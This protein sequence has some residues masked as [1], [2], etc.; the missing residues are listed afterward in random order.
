MLRRL[1]T[2]T[3]LACLTLPAATLSA[4]TESVAQQSGQ[5]DASVLQARAEGV[6]A[7][8][9]GEANA[10]EVFAPSFLAEVPAE[11]LRALASQLAGQFGTLQRLD[12]VTQAPDGS[13]IIAI[14][15]ENALAKGP[16]SLG[17]APGFLVQG[18]LINVVQTID[19]SAE[20]IF[21]DLAA[22]PGEVG[23]LFA[24]L[25][26]GLDPILALNADQQFAIGSTF[27]LYI[28]SALARQIEAGERKWSDVVELDRK[29]FPSGRMQTW[30][31]DAPVTLHTLATMMISISDNTA[32]DRLLRVVGREMVEAELIDSGNSSPDRTLPFLSTLE[33]FALKGSEPNLRKYEAASEEDQ[34]RILADFEDDTGGD[35]NLITPPTFTEPL[36]IDTVEWF[37]SGEDL[38]KLGVLLAEFEDPTAREIMAVSPAMGEPSR[39]KWAY[40]G[41]KGGSEPGVLNL[42]WLL[43]DK[44]GVWHVLAMSWNNSDATVDQTKFELLAQR[45]LALASEE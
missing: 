16:I 40:V 4:Q 31:K 33:M 27:K 9:K 23:V 17:A 7:V 12:S 38:R 35:R 34:R 36:A 43:Q 14:R 45:I 22:L 6:V 20:A 25:E 29:S 26:G 1:M 19:D 21:T 3:A 28:L 32:T 13:S 18:L 10:A 2:A 30:P 8:L 44:A 24:P 37:A 5:E 41:Y 39:D 15:F 42:T 11:R